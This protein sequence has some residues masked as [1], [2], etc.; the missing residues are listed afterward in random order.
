MQSP[1]KQNNIQVCESNR[2]NKANKTQENNRA[3]IEHQSEQS[4]KN[5]ENM[6]NTKSKTTMSYFISALSSDREG[7]FC[8]VSTSEE[9]RVELKS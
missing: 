1:E 8:N 4:Q 6:Y 5:T 7:N 3:S 2:D 9:P